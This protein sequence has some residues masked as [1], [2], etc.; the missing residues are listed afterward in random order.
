M[1]SSNEMPLN[2]TASYPKGGASCFIPPWIRV[3]LAAFLYERS[4]GGDIVFHNILRLDP[5]GRE[6]HLDLE[7]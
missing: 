4:L 2:L 6:Y 1:I 5:G 3:E 7:D